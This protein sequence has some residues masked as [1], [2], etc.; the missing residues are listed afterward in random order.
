ME[1]QV[2]KKFGLEEEGLRV[3]GFGWMKA[4][5]ITVSGGMMFQATMIALHTEETTLAGSQVHVM[6]L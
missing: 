1:F 4:S 2:E 3:I 5:G 6:K